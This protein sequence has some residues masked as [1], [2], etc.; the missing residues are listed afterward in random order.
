MEIT[1]QNYRQLRN[2][3]DT[4]KLSKEVLEVFNDVDADFE[5]YLDLYTDASPENDGI[6][7]VVNNHIKLVNKY[8]GNQPKENKP[9][10]KKE[11]T[12]VV[13]WEGYFITRKSLSSDYSKTENEN[14]AYTWTE[15]EKSDA[16]KVAKQ[17]D[18]LVVTMEEALKMKKLKDD[19][20]KN[21]EK[22]FPTPKKETLQ[23][24]FLN[25]P[26]VRMLMPKLQQMAV[27]E[28]DESE[29]VQFFIDKVKELE[30]IFVDA[31]KIDQK[32]PIM[33]KIVKIHYFYGSTD[34]F[35]F[36]YDPKDNVFFGYVVL[37]GDTEMSE[38]GYISVDE[39]MSVKRLELDFYFDQEPLGKV[40]H[41][42]YPDDFP[43]YSKQKE[44]QKS[45]EPAKTPVQKAKKLG[46]LL[47]EYANFSNR[48]VKEMSAS[49]NKLESLTYDQ[50]NDK[51]QKTIIEVGLLLDVRYSEALDY[52]KEWVS[53]NGSL[54]V[55]D[56]KKYL[57]MAKQVYNIETKKPTAKKP[58][59]KP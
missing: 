5:D 21:R 50:L 13:F 31:K 6:R 46:Q 18:G 57:E 38:A 35:I 34:W 4:S 40:L 15:S 42:R 33:D 23:D 17:F 37:N 22:N 49:K 16:E 51:L 39:I 43:V 45:K 36:D 25:A 8:F 41:S 54:F 20:Q 3:F 26:M 24:A 11:K 48:M 29:E 44:I 55:F 30:A 47:Y 58:N 2:S 9:A 10:P 7:D 56:Q 14:L 1:V 59:Q 32:T 12:Y 52:I 27:L 53:K 19:S 28:N